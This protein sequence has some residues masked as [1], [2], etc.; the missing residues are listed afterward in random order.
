MF[1]DALTESPDRRS[2]LVGRAQGMYAVTAQQELDLLFIANFA[3][4][5]GKYNGSSI[6]VVGRNPVADD[7]R[8]MA[9]VGGSGLFRLAQGYALAHTVA[10]D[11]TTTLQAWMDLEGGGNSFVEWLRSE[12]TNRLSECIVHHPFLSILSFVHRLML[13][14]NSFCFGIRLQWHR[15]ASGSGSSG[16]KFGPRGLNSPNSSPVSLL[17]LAVPLRFGSSRSKIWFS[18]AIFCV[19]FTSTINPSSTL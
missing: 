10:A 12:L 11:R 19:F 14:T 13:E 8:E 6:A 15:S 7:V 5:E 1:D 9:V 4:T 3:F 18:D 16:R 17:F 2:K